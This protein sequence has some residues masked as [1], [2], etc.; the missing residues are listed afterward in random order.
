V[1]LK[2]YKA[3]NNYKPKA[4]FST[5]AFAIARNHCLNFIKSKRYIQTTKSV[6]LN[7]QKKEFA[8]N[9]YNKSVAKHNFK[10]KNIQDKLEQAVKKLSNA[11]KEAFLL[12]AVEGYT[13]KEIALISG[14]P[15]VTIRTNYHRARMIL[16]NKLGGKKE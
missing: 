4:K 13:Y 2:I 14:Q 6:S 12:H 3:K 8:S 7:E 11:H 15:P 1:F 9:L 16:M 10:T 5:W